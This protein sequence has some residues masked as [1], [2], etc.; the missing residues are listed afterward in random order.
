MLIFASALAAIIPMFTY[1]LI[2]WRLD[3]YDKEPFKFVLQN[4]F[5]GAFGAIIFSIIGSVF[6]SY[7]LSFFTTDKEALDR[8]GTILVAPVVEE[9]MKGVFL[10]M[11]VTYRKFDNLT[12]GIV[13]GGAIGLG[14]GMTENFLYFISY[15]ETLGGW[16]AIVIIRTLF[17][18]VMHCV[19]TGT[20][21][22]FLGIAKYKPVPSKIIL[23]LTGYFVAVLIHFTW[24]LTVSFHST[25]PLG[26]VIMGGT[27][28]LFVVVF[29]STVSGER[30]II[31][32][33]LKSEAELGTIP[34]NHL[35]I[36]SSSRRN[37]NGWIDE[38]IRKTYISAATTLAFRKM[39]SEKSTGESRKSYLAEI[40]I[41][42]QFIK[43]IL[44]T[45][46]KVNE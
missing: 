31:L 36:L 13:Y 35:E 12:D 6:F 41:Y 23:T 15:G 43:S 14:F 38:R 42:R 8:F 16:I 30:K 9:F 4:Y 27:I 19:S 29:L 1:L 17:S 45:L 33:E 24:N 5:W 11:I 2:I 20:F 26:F 39:Q 21:G 40:N 32:N 10:L 37:I 18:A 3:R 46:S 7:L 22:A 34:V 44:G 28:V 25:A